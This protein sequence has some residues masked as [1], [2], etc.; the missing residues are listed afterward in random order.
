[1]SDSVLAH[2]IPAL[3]VVFHPPRVLIKWIFTFSSFH[4]VFTI[5]NKN[6]NTEGLGSD[7]KRLS[8]R[9][10]KTTSVQEVLDDGPG[11]RTEL[12]T[13]RFRR[14]LCQSVDFLRFFGV[15]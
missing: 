12:K 10:F 11:R 7:D 14:G 6:Q 8:R 2:L 13:L 3:H 15:T 1:M 5:T 4:S 9:H